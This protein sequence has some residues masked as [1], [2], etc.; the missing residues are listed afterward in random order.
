MR[1]F[2][3]RV[4]LAL[5]QPAVARA[6][7]AQAAE[8]RRR[9]TAD[10]RARA[11]H[12]T[13]LLRLAEG[14]RPGARRALARGISVVDEYRATLGATELR[15]HASGHGIDLARLG[16]R[17]ALED[18]RPAQV[19]R[20]AERG[21]AGALRRPAVRPPDDERLATELAELR[22]IRTEAREA[23]IQGSSSADLRARAAAVEKS[24]RNRTRRTADGRGRDEWVEAADTGRVDVASVR[25]ALGDRVLVEY[26]ALEGTLHAVVVTRRRTLLYRLG[27]V[28][29]VDRERRYLLFA[30]RRL[31]WPRSR[32]AAESG[33]ETTA[34]RLDG[35]L[36]GRLRLPSGVPLVVVPTGALHGLPWTTLPTLAGRST[37]IAPST[38]LW[39]GGTTTAPAP[40]SPSPSASPSPPGGRV[41][42]VALV[43]GPQLPGADAELR[44]LAELYPDATMLAGA[45]A[46]AAAVLAAM[47]R[48]DLVHLAAHG[49]FRADSPLF[50][51]VLLADGPL[52]VYDLERLRRAP[53]VVVLSACEAAVA[54]V[55][56]GDELLGTAAALLALGVRAVIA[57]LMPVPDAATTEVMVALHHRLRAGERPAEALAHAAEGRDRAATAAFVCIGR[58]DA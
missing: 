14:D 25:E 2:V 38:A 45:S 12:A 1:T 51:S 16:V 44:Q 50:S 20:W 52:T 42:R 4:A 21:R 39:L 53:A 26:V 23:A 33:V 6:E 17:L 27:P 22:R 11:W 24:V 57:P 13:A 28:A 34:A 5:G 19:L 32:A 3:G 54:A 30:L 55:H 49:S 41:G 48:S 10:L 46:T 40:P 31:L 35:L 58:D 18:G 37:T 7:L 43:A 29:D 8:A 36:L 9:G 15:A 56:D 47:E